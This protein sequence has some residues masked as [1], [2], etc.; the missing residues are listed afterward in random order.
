MIE[1]S[2][3]ARLERQI[4]LARDDQFLLLSDNVLDAAG[5]PLVHRSQLPLDGAIG[6]CG[7]DETREGLLSTTAKTKKQKPLARVLP[8]AL[9]E[10]R[11]DTHAGELTCDESDAGRHLQWTQQSAGRN[12][13][14][15]LFV[16]LSTTRL[17]KEC[18]WR[19]LTVAQA[20]EIQSPDVAV[21][22]R[23]QCGREQWLI[24]RSLEAKAN[25]TLL[26]HNLSSECL[27]A[28]FLAPLG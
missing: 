28:R 7:E 16:D 19:Q 25:R 9:P 15:P 13:A 17:K 2:G 8:L 6:F 24:Y 4:L 5:G 21:G 12:L 18:T 10:W 27:V 26:G 23:V 14:C 3:G 20:L 22:Y 11:V 1:L